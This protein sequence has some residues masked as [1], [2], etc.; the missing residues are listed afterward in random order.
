MEGTEAV[1][2]IS[3]ADIQVLIDAITAQINVGT[4]VAILA[5]VIGLAVTFVFMWW[6]IR[7]VASMF[8]SAFKKGKL[9]V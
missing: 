6:G 2:Q 9:S 8:M 1:T 5:A 4:V 3:V 7:K